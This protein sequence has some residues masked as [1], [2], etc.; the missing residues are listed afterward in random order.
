MAED[1][2]RVFVGTVGQ[3]VW[4][5][6]DGGGCFRRVSGGMFSECQIRALLLRPDSPATLYAGTDRG[7][8]RSDDG[9]DSWRH[10]TSPLDGSQGWSLALNPD[11]PDELFAGTCPAALYRSRDGGEIWQRLTVDLPD[12]CEGTL[13]IPRITCITIDPADQRR[14]Y[15]GVEIGG[16][17]RSRDGG[18]SWQALGEGLSSQDIHGLVVCPG[19]PR[20]LI[21]TTNNDVNRSDDDGESWQPLGVLAAFPWPY[22][23]G[24]AAAPD[25]PDT[26]YVGAGNGPPG[27]RGALYRT[28]NRGA[29][30][31]ALP[32]PVQPNST[33]W[34][35]GFNAADPRRIYAGS[36]NGQ[37]FRSLDGG[38]CWEKLEQE[39]GEV[40]A[41]AWAPPL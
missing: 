4:R 30:W 25:D 38:T 11:R 29:G 20:S 13:I 39:F 7:V 24:R 31:E 3:S 15:A 23:R 26:I 2:T 22:C 21:A 19:P 17:R 34:N 12:R 10:L 32:L 14:V 36:I 6:D 37:I 18:D 9:G 1:R 35:L 27:D 41:L 33:I 40:R 8:Y 5:S 16:V 28:R